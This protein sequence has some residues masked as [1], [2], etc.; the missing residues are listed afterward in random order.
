MSSA[1]VQQY[2]G[3]L[4]AIL[5]DRGLHDAERS[6][7]S[8]KTFLALPQAVFGACEGPK[9][10][11]Q[12][13]MIWPTSMFTNFERS[14]RSLLHLVEITRRRTR[15]S[16]PQQRG[17]HFRV[18]LPTALLDHTAQV[19]LMVSQESGIRLQFGGRG[20]RPLRRRHRGRISKVSP[21]PRRNRRRHRG[22]RPRRRRP[23]VL[24]GRG[25]GIPGGGREVAGTRRHEP[26]VFALSLDPGLPSCNVF[27]NLRVVHDSRLFVGKLLQILRQPLRYLQIL[28]IARA[29]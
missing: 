21:R 8:L 16:E 11:N 6:A 10:G 1:Q 25:G 2:L 24:G 20:R 26:Q 22:R 13:G 27:V 15:G 19:V 18:P 17:A 4:H 23:G 9:N 5:P 29:L 3:Q 12:T 14:L 28:L 7:Q